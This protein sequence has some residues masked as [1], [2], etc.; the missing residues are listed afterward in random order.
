MV[1][2]RGYQDNP[3]STFTFP[4]KAL[5][6]PV[7][8]R[9]H[10]F[11]SPAMANPSTY[12]FPKSHSF[13]PMYSLQKTIAT[14]HEQFKRWSSIILLYCKSH[15]IW[16]LQLSEALNSPLFH[17]IQLRKRLTLLEVREIIDWM[18][19]EEGMQGAEWFG[20]EGE[21]G[22]AWIYWRR[23]EEWADV[24]AS[25]V[26]LIFGRFWERVNDGNRWR[27]RARRILF[28]LFMNLRRE[29]RL[30]RKV[31]DGFQSVRYASPTHALQN[32]TAWILSFCRRHFRSLSSAAKRRSSEAKSTKVSNS[33]NLKSS[34]LDEKLNVWD[35]YST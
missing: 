1:M 30:H 18:T 23:P 35:H 7:P 15:K 20:K 31:K 26:S 16:R 24:L 11:Q 9:D 22:S 14:R 19:S 25:W 33:S 6:L 4:I 17:N 8:S 10:P 2:I 29:R 12:T 5:N 27:K 28:L 32:S 13:P 21:K 34:S 3:T